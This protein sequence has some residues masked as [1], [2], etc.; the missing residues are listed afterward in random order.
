[1]YVIVYTAVQT[2]HIA[3]SLASFFTV[4]KIL[5][6]SSFFKMEALLK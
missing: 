6:L 3:Y 2:Y 4:T 5:F 1:M